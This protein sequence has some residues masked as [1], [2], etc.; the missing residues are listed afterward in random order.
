[1]RRRSPPPHFAFRPHSSACSS[2]GARRGGN[3]EARMTN[4]DA[5]Y[6]A[7]CGG[8]RGA[9]KHIA[10][11]SPFLLHGLMPEN[12]EPA[13]IQRPTPVRTGGEF[14]PA[15]LR[16]GPLTAVLI[17]ISVAVA[18]FSRLGQNADVLSSLFI[19]RYRLRDGEGFLPEIVQG[20]VWR[21]LTPIFIHFGIMHLVFNMLWLKDLGSMIEKLVSTWVLLA[22]VIVIGI[23][24]N[25]GQFYFHGPFFGGM[26][27]IVYGLLGYVWM[28]S[29]FDPASGLFLEKQT[30]TWMIGWFFLCLTGAMGSVANYAH[31]IGLV[32]GMIWGFTSAKMRSARP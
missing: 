8:L 21:L 7:A 3:A 15:S 18:I 29:K 32:T 10:R 11:G 31:G 2:D 27:G 22:L 24:S 1:M 16:V 25:L 28:K 17:A 13:E 30:V 4:D 9:L 23:P 5:D 6:S 26:S 14:S 19:T 12:Q 20:Q